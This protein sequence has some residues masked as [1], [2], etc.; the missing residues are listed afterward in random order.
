MRLLHTSDWHIGHSLGRNSRLGEHRA[1][2]EW[3]AGVIDGEGV[4]C[5]VIA[6]DVFDSAAPSTR[7]QEL[8]YRFLCRVAAG[9]CRHVVVIAGNHDSP[10]LLDAP[11]ELLRALNIYVVGGAE[12]NPEDEAI[13][14]R[15][16]AGAPE[17][18]VC[19]VP[20][21]RDR[22]VRESA[23][24]ESAEEKERKLVDGI[25]AQYAAVL[26][27][28]R[29]KG[30]A[31]GVRAPV[32][33]TGHL[34][35][36][37]GSGGAATADDGVRDL[38]VGSLAHVP[39]DVFPAGFD[40]VALGHLHTPQIV[41]GDA[42]RRYAGAPL[43]MGFG[44]AGREKSVCI[45]DIDAGIDAVAVHVRTVPVP[46]FQ[47]LEKIEGDWDGIAARLAACAALGESIWLD[48]EYT[49]AELLPDL[50]A[51][52]AALVEGS[53]LTVVKIG[54]RV[55]VQRALEGSAAGETLDDLAPADVFER[56]LDAQEIAESDR[57][58]LRRAH[59]EILHALQNRDEAAHAD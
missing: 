38:Y 56:C 23:A 57:D 33:A 39:A 17:L 44:E 43:A 3:L 40:Y 37:G 51:R 14:L 47:K 31:A 48:V 8:Y 6:G 52:I 9:R 13:V 27:A 16:A 36:A 10:S 1:F 21:L 45:V 22:D 54:N 50:R 35:A 20:F 15:D 30:D 46:V 41:G 26:A 11:R 42:T 59:E 12:E 5:L 53:A 29:A 55:L 19:A 25:R 32:I 28:A 24:G 34:F 58:E 4:D 2:L 7:A 18:L 49:G